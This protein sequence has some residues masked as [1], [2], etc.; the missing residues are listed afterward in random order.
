MSHFTLPSGQVPTPRADR[1]TSLKGNVLSVHSRRCPQCPLNVRFLSARCP[2]LHSR[3]FP[4]REF[5]ESPPNLNPLPL[6]RAH[7]QTRPRPDRADPTP[8]FRRKPKWP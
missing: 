2:L 3:P 1:R 7:G 4:F 6:A 5:R 8:T